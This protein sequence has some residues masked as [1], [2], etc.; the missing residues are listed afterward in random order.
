MSGGTVAEALAPALTAEGLDKI[1]HY[2][3]T[4]GTY[5][6]LDMA[7]QP[8][9][10]FLVTFLPRRLAPN[11]V[12]LCG[13]IPV[14]IA[15]VCLCLTGPSL[16]S[17]PPGWCLLLF[18]VASVF[19]V[20]MD[21]LDGKQARRTGS[22]SPLGHLFDHGVDALVVLPYHAFIILGVVGLGPTRASLATQLVVQGSFFLAQWQE[23]HT[24]V[25][26][27]AGISEMCFLASIITA[28]A[29]C[30]QES[31]KEAVLQYQIPVL[32]GASL[33]ASFLGAMSINGAVY[34]SFF[35]VSTLLA[36]R[37]N[38][39]ACGAV[40]F[41]LT[42]L[43]GT[44]AGACLWPEA[45]MAEAG[46]PILLTTGILLFFLTAQMI[47]F[48]MA[49]QQFPILQPTVAFYL[50]LSLLSRFPGAEVLLSHH[51]LWLVATTLIFSVGCWLVLIIQQ[52]KV[53]LG[54]FALAMPPE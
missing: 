38:G 49:G 32:G 39:G 6:A 5:S 15:Y 33:R 31:T 8:T 44:F 47:T 21:N 23:R 40:L 51:L 30:M 37:R 45:V 19:Y 3:Y 26:P 17:T 7:L 48:S 43:A 46:L 20:A 36:V 42:P 9:W 41:E 28:I 25:C 4:P 2:G 53:R 10:N 1:A 34:L 18:A 27:T 24:S 35:T 12:T 52:L 16:E 54:I 29:G 14:L 11:C 50:G 22:S 13:L